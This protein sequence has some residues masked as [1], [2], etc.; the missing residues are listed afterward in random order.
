MKNYRCGHGRTFLI[1]ITVNTF[2]LLTSLSKSVTVKKMNSTSNTVTHSSMIPPQKDMVSYFANLAF[3]YFL[4]CFLLFIGTTI[5]GKYINLYAFNLIPGYLN[6]LMFIGMGC[7]VIYVGMTI[8]MSIVFYLLQL[9]WFPFLGVK[10]TQDVFEKIT[11]KLSVLFS[12]FCLLIYLFWSIPHMIGGILVESTWVKWTQTGSEIEFKN[13]DLILDR[14]GYN[15][16]N[17]T[18]YWNDESPTKLP[19]VYILKFFN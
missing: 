8:A 19:G 2:I 6:G 14:F 18:R 12:Y 1:K 5:L 15:T 11:D 3:G 9:F 7:F 13:R 16:T 10:K 17:S 4:L